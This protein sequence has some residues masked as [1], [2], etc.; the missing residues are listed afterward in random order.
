MSYVAAGLRI[1]F[2]D[3][4]YFLCPTMTCRGIENIE[5]YTEN[6][7]FK[8]LFLLESFYFYKYSANGSI[9]LLQNFHESHRTFFIT[10]YRKYDMFTLF[11]TELWKNCER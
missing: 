1:S 2:W 8:Y 7:S 9:L 6:E 3:K 11:D 4:S 10:K 5:I